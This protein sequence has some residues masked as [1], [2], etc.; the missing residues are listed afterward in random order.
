MSKMS[1]SSLRF[2]QFCNCC[3]KVTIMRLLSKGLF[4]HIWIQKV[5]NL[6]I[7]IRLVSSIH[8]S[9]LS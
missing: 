7:F 2:G 6:A 1:F 8:F 3:P 4:F 9:T 5:R